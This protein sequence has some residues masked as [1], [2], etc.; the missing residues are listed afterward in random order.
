MKQNYSVEDMQ[1]TISILLYYIDKLSGPGMHYRGQ[2]PDWYVAAAMISCNIPD[3]NP[4]AIT[5]VRKLN[6]D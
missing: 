6:N 5:Y 1:E 3:T 2:T 4:S